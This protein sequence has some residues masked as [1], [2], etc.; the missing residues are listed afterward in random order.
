[1]PRVNDTDSSFKKTEQV[2]GRPATTD[3]NIN[4]EYFRQPPTNHLMRGY[5]S[6][7]QNEGNA[8]DINGRQYVSRDDMKREERESKFA[9]TGATRITKTDEL[10]ESVSQDDSLGRRTTYQDVDEL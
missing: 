9:T 5:V 6:R 7:N 2:V 4:D 3:H 1:M 10:A 8:L